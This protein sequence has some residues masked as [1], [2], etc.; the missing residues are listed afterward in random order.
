M[1]SQHDQ[2]ISL[3][4]LLL[5]QAVAAITIVAAACRAWARTRNEPE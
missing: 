3:D 4:G 5:V 2:G 1:S